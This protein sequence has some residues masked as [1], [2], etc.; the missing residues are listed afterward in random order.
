MTYLWILLCWVQFTHLG[1]C[2]HRTHVNI[3][4][5]LPASGKW[6]ETFIL[7]WDK[8]W[9]QANSS[10]SRPLA[11]LYPSRF[12]RHV[13]DTGR[14]W[15][16]NLGHQALW[17]RIVRFSKLQ[18]R[19]PANLNF[20]SS[21][22]IFSISMSSA[23]FWVY[24]LLKDDLSLIYSSN[25]TLAWVFCILSGNSTPNSSVDATLLTWSEDRPP[26]THYIGDG[27]MNLSVQIYTKNTFYKS[28]ANLCCWKHF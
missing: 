17:V 23:I 26:L 12:L 25:L 16:L 14:L 18:Y 20:R 3:P 4:C 28:S 22:D 9:V 10:L 6:E 1:A 19:H 13:W 2:L 15:C 21:T 11:N 7:W 5:P 27:H 24:F 8:W